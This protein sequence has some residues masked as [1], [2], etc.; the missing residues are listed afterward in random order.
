MRSMKRRPG[1]FRQVADYPWPRILLCFMILWDGWR[2][3]RLC[4][5]KTRSVYVFM[6]AGRFWQQL[7]EN[8]LSLIFWCQMNTVGEVL[9]L[10]DREVVDRRTFS[11][12]SSEISCVLSVPCRRCSLHGTMTI[13]SL[14][15][16]ALCSPALEHTPIASIARMT[17]IQFCICVCVLFSSS[18]IT[19]MYAP[20]YVDQRVRYVQIYFVLSCIWSWSIHLQLNCLSLSRHCHSSHS[21]CMCGHVSPSC[22][23]NVCFV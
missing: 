22:S 10:S 2:H 21:Y 14:K 8:R 6:F 7:V 3:V 17:K 23:F 18:Y 11:N 15:V 13:R 5:S 16:S 12:R 1:V 4:L 20:S 19:E 9:A